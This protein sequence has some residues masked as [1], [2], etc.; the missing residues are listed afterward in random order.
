MR[1][2]KMFRAK[3]MGRIGFGACF[4]CSFR[5]ERFVAPRKVPKTPITCNVTPAMLAWLQ[6]KM[7]G[8]NRTRFIELTTTML[9]IP[10]EPA[11]LSIL[12]HN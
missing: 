10:P 6:S 8:Q 7:I 5:C 3:I 12:Q 2:G 9:G 11:E 4:Q 1:R